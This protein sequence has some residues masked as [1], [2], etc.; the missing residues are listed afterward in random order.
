MKMTQFE[1][2]NLSG[3]QKKF[4]SVTAIDS[5]D[6]ALEVGRC[7]ALVG[8]NGA[9]K[10]TL[11]K[12]LLGLVRPDQGTVFVLGHDPFKGDFRNSRKVIGFLPEQIL[13][14]KNMTGTETLAFYAKLK[15]LADQDFEKLFTRVGLEGAA[16]RKVGTYSKGMRQKLGM[17]QALMG[18]PKLLILDEPTT[19]LDPLARQNIYRIINEEK[20]RGATVLISSH[21]L[22]ELD[23]R[24][25][26]V[27]IMKAGK[28]VAVGPIPELRKKLGLCTTVSLKAE[29][30][31]CSKIK[32][33]FADRFEI[34]AP[35]VHQLKISC[36]VQ[37]K[38]S[39]LSEIMELGVQI[40]DIELSEPTL[41][42]VYN[43]YSGS[44]VAGGG[45][46]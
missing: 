43:T 24:I 10:S 30:R 13:F 17:A 1:A 8:H 45:N 5:V 38:V 11:I 7:V 39:L 46:G 28:I 25:D 37:S 9:G 22:T 19:G 33:A 34:A 31:I 44:I 35:V 16:D 42:D 15:R 32:Q 4:G 27:A 12:I 26:Q 41:E 14:Q 40:S 2:V 36:P 20:A 23:D 6:L 29:P 21:A 18:A 3:V